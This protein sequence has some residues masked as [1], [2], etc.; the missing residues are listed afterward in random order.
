VVRQTLS[1]SLGGETR[2]L[3]W[4]TGVPCELRKLTLSRLYMVFG[5]VMPG[6]SGKKSEKLLGLMLP[7][8]KCGDNAPDR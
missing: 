2:R 6:G 1:Y 4:P 8:D 5:I 3:D 7:G